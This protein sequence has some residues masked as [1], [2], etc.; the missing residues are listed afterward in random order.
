MRIP[1]TGKYGAGKALLIDDDDYRH[2]LSHSWS[3]HRKGYLIYSSR[4]TGLRFHRLVMNA[5]PGQLVD[6]INGDRLDNRKSNLRL[7]DNSKNLANRGPQKNN[8]SGFK[9]VYWAKDVKKWK[10]QIAFQGKRM[11]I[12]STSN[13]YEAVKMYDNKAVE[14]FGEFAKPNLPVT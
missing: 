2:Y 12:G 8:T 7:C 3:V 4:G 5:K 13:I 14:L 9:G 10:A 6:H 1:L 11:Y